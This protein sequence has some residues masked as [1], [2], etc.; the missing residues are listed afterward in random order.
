M[1]QIESPGT[2]I[3][4]IVDHGLGETRRGFPQFVARFHLKQKYVE[5]L[6]ELKGFYEQGV[7]E[8][9]DDSGQT[10]D[11]QWVDWSHFD[12]YGTGYFVLFNDTDSFD[13]NSKLFHYDQLQAATGWQGVEFESFND[14]WFVDKDVLIRVEEDEYNGETRLKIN[15]IDSKDAAPDRGRGVQK[16]EPE[17]VKS[18]QSKL[19]MGKKSGGAKASK[20]SKPSKPQQEQAES[21]EPVAEAPNTPA[22]SDSSRPNA[23]SQTDAWEFVCNHKGDNI[24][25]AIEDAWISACE[26]VGAETDEDDFTPEMWAQVRDLVIKDLALDV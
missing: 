5:D 19:K 25:S 2:Y 1:A 18:L 9:R 10:F 22:E 7:V 26:E 17:K 11:P 21:A 13:E 3:A 12:E 24:D 20:P 15:T 4:T 23:V 16:A 14:G 8:A 6:H